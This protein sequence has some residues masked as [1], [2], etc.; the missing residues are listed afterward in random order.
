[1]S[2]SHLKVFDAVFWSKF[3]NTNL[4]GRHYLVFRINC[5]FILATRF[6][7]VSLFFFRSIQSFR[8]FLEIEKRWRNLLQFL[9]KKYRLLLGMPNKFLKYRRPNRVYKLS[10]FQVTVVVRCFRNKKR[11]LEL[12]VLL[13]FFFV[14]NS[15]I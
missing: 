8:N 10:S 2:S 9:L 3:H 11:F 1:V 12:S 14:D 13:S 6:Q 15:R 4:I 5:F 7:T